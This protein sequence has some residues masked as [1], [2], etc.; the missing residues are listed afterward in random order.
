MWQSRIA[1]LLKFC[2]KPAAEAISLTLSAQLTVLPVS[3]FVFGEAA[4][5]SLVSNVLVS[6]FSSAVIILGMAFVLF[7]A[8]PFL[9]SLLALLCRIALSAVISVSY[10][11][12]AL[13]G[14]SI[15]L[16]RVNVISLCMYYAVMLLLF[17]H[18]RNNN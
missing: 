2:P 8:V 12:A 15:Q 11:I 14:A 17:F 1:S 5:Y 10:V 18:F 6:V 13:P 16:G 3:A 4:L 7:S 9:S